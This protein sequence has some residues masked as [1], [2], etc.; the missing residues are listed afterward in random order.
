M[1]ECPSSASHTPSL[2]ERLRAS[3]AM[4][5]VALP[6][7]PAIGTRILELLGPDSRASAATVAQMIQHE[8][9]V[10]ASLLRMANSAA[11]GGLNAVS[12]LSQA[13]SRLGFPQVASIVTTLVH[14]GHFEAPTADKRRRLRV[15]W[16]HAVA[17]AIAAR[18]VSAMCGGDP[19]QAYLAGLLH[20]VGKL[21]VL[22]GVDHLEA[23][24]SGPAITPALCDEAMTQLHAELGHR[25]LTEWKL[26][27]YVAQVA[28]RH[29][30]EAPDP[31]L[32]L[33]LRVQ[34]ANAVARTVAAYPEPEPGLRL[35]EVPAVEQL[36]LSEL[37]LAALVVDLE[38]DMRQVNGLA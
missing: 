31:D 16:D 23:T 2:A 12:D 28:L 7:L 22:R 19:E 38:D 32:T 9:V 8:P 25:V 5:T 6:P 3:A 17:T 21:L 1:I 4:G 27:D 11:F 26:P 34:V 15:L 20:D 13:V 30:D 29:H 37:E 35:S 18:R 10:A 33:L 24:A 14:R 36:A